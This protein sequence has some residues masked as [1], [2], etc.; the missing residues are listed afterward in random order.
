MMF[1]ALADPTWRAILAGLRRGRRPWRHPSRLEAAFF[2]R[3]S[4]QVEN[5]RRS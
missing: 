5:C 3:F 1:A 4:E 2:E